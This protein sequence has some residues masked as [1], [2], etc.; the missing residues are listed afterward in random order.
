MAAVGAVAVV[1]VVTAEAVVEAVV[2]CPAVAAAVMGVL[3]CGWS[4]CSSVM[5][6]DCLCPQPCHPLQLAPM[7]VA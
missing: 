2:A 5:G 1:T 3:A 6:A 4:V 7:P